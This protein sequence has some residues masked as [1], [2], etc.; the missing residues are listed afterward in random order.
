MPEASTWNAERTR[1]II[2]EYLGLEGP[3]LPILHAL[4]E[5]YG[6]ISSDAIPV[7]ADALNLTRA[8]VHGV[9]TF[10]HDFRH[11]PC[12]QSSSTA[13]RGEAC[14]SVGSEA[15]RQPYSA[16]LALAGMAPQLM[17]K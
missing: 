1:E 9:V 16:S 13:C 2:A 8:E 15:W 4:Q 11:E 17:A 3:M 12:G 6:F 5:E 7:I 14:Q 10:Y